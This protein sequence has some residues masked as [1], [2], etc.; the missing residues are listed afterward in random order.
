M[1]RI[2]SR[3]LAAAAFTLFF[4]YEAAAQQAVHRSDN[5]YDI[6]VCGPANAL[7]ARC[8]A[9]I[10]TDAAGHPFASPPGVISGYQPSQLRSAY[11][12][13]ALGKSTNAIAI[14]AGYGYD[15]AE[16]DLGVYRAQWGLPRC[17][18]KSG[19]FSKFNQ[20]GQKGNYPTQNNGWALQSAIELDM[21]SAMCERCMLFLIE[22]DDDSMKNLALA[23]NE[24]ATLGA[25]V[26]IAGYGGDEVANKK[27]A[28]YYDHSGLAVVTS[29]GDDGYGV[30][31]PATSPHVIAVGATKLSLSGGTRLSETVSS[32]TG[33]G[34]STVFKKPAWQ[35][36]PD[37]SMRTA[38]DVSADGDGSTGVAFYGPDLNSG[39]PGW[40][41]GAGTAVSASIVG[42]IYGLGIKPIKSASRLYSHG[43][44]LYDIT[45][46]SNGSCGSAYL[47]HGVTGYDGPSGMGSPNGPAAF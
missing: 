44:D 4:S 34:C 5:A 20:L 41:V 38:N 43:S 3:V 46:G 23:A 12:I 36:D 40:F 10:V 9:R 24:A 25:H 28:K 31:F 16:A 39:V 14:I 17:T 7:Q 11:S 15:N 21:A 18:S 13:N 29:A 8:Q 1:D 19:C 2:L 33:S 26:I 45:S 42:G 22:A 30:I 37:C 27:L 47:C 6:A 32:L 35:H